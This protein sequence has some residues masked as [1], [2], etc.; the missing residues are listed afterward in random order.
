MKRKMSCRGPAR[1]WQQLWASLAAASLLVA[2]GTSAA[3]ADE[4]LPPVEVAADELAGKKVN[5]P[6]NDGK[7]HQVTWDKN[8]FF[9]DGQRLHV[10]SGELHH[11]RLPSPEH[12][13]DIFQKLRAAGFNA[14][15]LYFFHGLHQSQEGGAYDFSGIKDIDRLL[16]MA[17]EE[18]LYVIARPGPY[19]NAE[20]SMGGLPAYMSN[21]T[22]HSLRSV[23][24]LDS[25][26][27]WLGKFNEIAKRHQVTDGGGSIIMYQ[28]ENELLGDE[29]WRK[30]FLRELTTFIK[31]DGITVPVF[32]NDW[33]MGGR[34]RN[35]QEVGTDFYAYDWYPAGFNCGNQRGGFA[36]DEAK[37]RGIAPNTPMFITEAQGGAFTPWG[38]AF[39]TDQCAVYTDPAFTREFGLVNLANGVTAFNYYMIIGG[40]N[41]G[42]TG[43]PASGFTSYDYG[44]ALN[45]DRLI[46]PKLAVQKEL[47]YWQN[48]VPQFASMDPVAAPAV[49]GQAAR[50]VKAYARVATDKASSATGNG[51]RLLAFRHARANSEETTQFTVPLS[52]GTAG[53]IDNGVPIAPGDPRVVY[54]GTVTDGENGVK[55]LSSDGATA[56]LQFTG[57]AIEV[58]AN[59]AIGGGNANVSVDGENVGS[60]QTHVD[61]LQNAQPVTVRKDFPAAGRHTVVVTTTGAQPVNLASF[62]VFG[63][64]Q[65]GGQTLVEEINNSDTNRIKFSDGWTQAANQGWTAGDINNDEAFSKRAGDSYE[66]TFTGTGIDIIAPFS[67]NH[68]P[69]DVFIDGVKVGR[70]EEQVTNSAVGQQVVFSKR[71]LDPGE[72]TLRV[73]VTGESFDGSTDTFV[74]LDA[75]RVYEGQAGPD[76]PNQPPAGELAW[77]RIPQKEGTS[78]TLQG[79][80]AVLV[81]ADA[82]LG[83]HKLL[84]STAQLFVNE[85]FGDRQFVAV[86]GPRDGAGE[87]VLAYDAEPTVSDGVEKNWDADRK[88]LR[89]NFTFGAEPTTITVQGATGKPLQVRVLDREAA[90]TAWLQHGAAGTG[91]LPVF[92]EGPYLARAAVF[93]GSEVNILGSATTA[94]PLRVFAPQGVTT[95]KWNGQALSAGEVF[96]GQAV[97]PVAVDTPT[98]T[99][100]KAEENPEALPE[101]DDSA[102]RVVDKTTTVNRWQRPGRASG[103]VMGSNAYKM[104]EGDV[105]YRGTYTA[106]SAEGVITLQGN[107][108]TGQPGHG[109]PPAFMLVWVN[110]H[111][112]GAVPAVGRQQR[113][114]IPAGAVQA[115]GKA[116]ISVL[117]HNMG[118]NLDW[119]DDGL[120]RQNRGLEDVAISNGDAASVVWKIQGA[121]DV[122]NPLDVTRTMYN[123]GGLYGERAGWYLPGYPTTGWKSATHLRADKPGVAWYRSAFDLDVPAGQ[124]VSFRLEVQSSRF[125]AQRRA[126]Q[127]EV[128]LFVNGWNTGVYVGDIGPQTSFTIPSGF[129]NPN[130][131]N[132]IAVAVTAK[133]AGHGPDNIVLRQVS[134][135]TGGLSYTP[136]LPGVGDFALTAQ[137]TP[138]QVAVGKQVSLTVQQTIPPLA[139]G[140][141]SKVLVDWGDGA[142]EEV[143]NGKFAH[144]YQQA[145]EKNVQLRLVDAVSG[146][147]LAQAT[148]KVTV[149]GPGGEPT[150]EPTD[151]PTT[152]PTDQPTTEPTDQPTTEPQPAPQVKRVAG[153]N[154]YATAVSALESG[155]FSK[156]GVVLAGGGSYADALAAAPLAG[157]I[158]APVLLTDGK[159]LPAVV[160]EAIVKFGP[161]TVYIVGGVGSVSPQVQAELEAAGLRVQRVSGRTRFETAS[162]VSVHT[163]SLLRARGV[164]VSQTKV[165]VADGINFPDALAAGAAASSTGSVLLL[166]DGT[167]LPQATRDFLDEQLP[168]AGVVAVGGNA[169]TATDGLDR[170]VQKVRG[171]NRYATSL[172]LAKVLR[173][174]AQRVIL[175]SGEQPWDA[176]GAGG[177]AK[178]QDAAVLLTPAK[179][180]PQEI[181]DYLAAQ[182]RDVTIL[183]G[184]GSVSSVV[185][186]QLRA[187]LR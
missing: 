130:G 26:K 165:L 28:A 147:T 146:G 77:N 158:D 80:D 145:G 15:S 159:H 46:T 155:K 136:Q 170:P 185:Q 7:P 65:S 128:L 168:A 141:L 32:H 22:Q 6:G 137:P 4:E 67:S 57:S 54:T 63:A 100:V 24:N 8:S 123:N 178:V 152:D 74:A 93:S 73:V 71:D 12:W 88:E 79:R 76:E 126:D 30:D 186:N 153:P 35:T 20:I 10:W 17:K 21:Y 84:Y 85:D 62:R 59:P 108:S 50:G 96:T 19:V 156:Q 138:A 44:A 60:L 95:V 70:T 115:N 9:V 110:G 51:T 164:D 97:A 94:H 133:T 114:N 127:S 139:G 11:W 106:N 118:Q 157:A 154:R 187:L 16:T 41:W 92:V 99:W 2:G 142:S 53:Q 120:S 107:G 166:S 40:T 112:A 161:R 148:T 49:E 14:V 89:L 47:G 27:E 163:L 134:N 122:D 83:D 162:R 86:V 143:T 117:V 173:P 113:V 81:T 160:R 38:A 171:A 90:A 13:R 167:K 37:F 149:T 87:M 131:R 111:Y 55:V 176:L 78:L 182:R 104:F 64:Q 33:G 43:A 101:F 36:D 169:I 140:T 183:G 56:T 5:F 150:T 174:Q 61:E 3:F 66:F 52:L 1:P 151:Q 180:L 75:L 29:Q 39:N 82:K 102:W 109:R 135:T 18:G 184:L 23:E 42:W 121:R 116:V 103:K 25:A 68:G 45:E 179:K 119:S 175:V 132:E 129:L 48:A 172:E 144:T 58:T 34:F 105:W 72:H 91:N 98:L 124:D 125:T 69:A 181:S 177:L 31:G